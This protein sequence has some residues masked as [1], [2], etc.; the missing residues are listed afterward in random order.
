MFANLTIYFSIVHINFLSFLSLGQSDTMWRVKL[1]KWGTYMS[2]IFCPNCNSF[3]SVLYLNVNQGRKKRT[4]LLILNNFYPVVSYRRVEKEKK[5]TNHFIRFGHSL[6]SAPP[7]ASARGSRWNYE[8]GQ[9]DR[10]FVRNF[11]DMKQRVSKI[12]EK[13]VNQKLA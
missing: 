9:N 4:S 6:W 7:V 12:F 3:L 5:A 10:F 13:Y 2:W 8:N 11:T 1:E